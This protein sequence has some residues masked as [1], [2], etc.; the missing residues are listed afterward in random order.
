MGDINNWFNISDI[1]TDEDS[2]DISITL[3]MRVRIDTA[4]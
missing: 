3:P 2:N 4:V 1:N